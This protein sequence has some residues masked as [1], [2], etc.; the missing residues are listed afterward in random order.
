MVQSIYSSLL[1][2]ISERKVASR[3]SL[4]VLSKPPTRPDGLAR[5]FRLVSDFGLWTISGAPRMSWLLI[6]VALVVPVLLD[7]DDCRV[8]LF[9]R[10]VKDD[11]E[12]G[13]ADRPNLI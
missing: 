6:V 9:L 7:T 11:D 4:A 13:E 3:S 10:L 2:F 1:F 8:L 5:S 12:D